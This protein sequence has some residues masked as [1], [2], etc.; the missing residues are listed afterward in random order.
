MADLAKIRER[1]ADPETMRQAT[2]RAD[3]I[4]DR[5]APDEAKLASLAHRAKVEPNKGKKII[6]LRKLAEPVIAAAKGIAPCHDGCSHCCHIP[7]LITAVEAR[8][9]AAE[10]GT[11]LR[12]P[13]AFS[14]RLNEE[15]T[16]IACTF[17]KDNRCSI[18]ESRPF[19][20]RIF[21]SVDRDNL[22]CEL[23]ANDRPTRVPYFNTKQWNF[24]FVNALMP[25][26]QCADIRDFFGTQVQE[27]NDE[28]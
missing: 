20:C 6:W 19:Q 21:Y 9:I 25:D 3:L 4:R 14:P 17:L 23:I 5:L 22:L 24:A 2:R 11:V 27:A 1:E 10:T 12:N 28:N 26:V 7:V 18:Y 13:N 8:V 15:Y 16:G